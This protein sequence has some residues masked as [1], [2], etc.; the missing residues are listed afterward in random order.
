MH[1]HRLPLFPSLADLWPAWEHRVSF[2]RWS[3]VGRLERS[4]IFVTYKDSMAIGAVEIALSIEHPIMA[5]M[6]CCS[7]RECKL[8]KLIERSCDVFCVHVCE[9][10]HVCKHEDLYTWCL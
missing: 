4:H 9:R 10:M 8:V 1:L 3:L 2:D 5:Q 7:N 6:D